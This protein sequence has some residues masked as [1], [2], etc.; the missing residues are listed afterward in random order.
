MKGVLFPEATTKLL[1]PE[2]HEDH[3]HALHVWRHPGG[4]MLISKWR[5]TWHERLCCLFTGHV[6]YMCWGDTHPPMSIEASH[7]FVTEGLIPRSLLKRGVI[8]VAV[9][10]ALL[11]YLLWAVLSK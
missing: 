7:P 8:P 11:C 2:G 4:G 10:L 6:W 3:I 1:P 9:L 5:M